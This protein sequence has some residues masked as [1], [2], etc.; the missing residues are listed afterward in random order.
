MLTPWMLA[1]VLFGAFLG[2]AALGLERVQRARGATAGRWGTR[3]GWT[4]ALLGAVLWPLA[5]PLWQRWRA[6][7]LGDNAPSVITTGALRATVIDAT[8][9]TTDGWTAWL[10]ATRATLSEGR[11]ALASGIEA[12]NAALQT[13]DAAGLSLTLVLVWLVLTGLL[14]LRLV[15]GAQSLRALTRRAQD[16]RVDGELVLLTDGF[17]PATV[18]WRAPRIVLPSWVRELDAP[19]RALI[20]AH[21]RAHR[22]ARDPRL[23]WLATLAVVLVPWNPSV[24]WIARRLRLAIELDCDART[25]AAAPQAITPQHYARLLLFMAQHVTPP[26]F[27]SAPLASAMASSRSHLQARIRSMHTHRIDPRSRVARRQR[28]VFGTVTV[29]AVAAACGTRIPSNLTSSTPN[30]VAGLSPDV[31]PVP[32]PN[33]FRD[34]VPLVVPGSASSPHYF[35]FQVERPA[36]MRGALGLRYPTVLRSAGV[37]GQVLASFV[38][39]EDGRVDSLTF[40]ALR[41]DHALFTEAVRA[42]LVNATYEA[43]EV[44]GRRVRQLVQQPFVFAIG[45]S[46]AERAAPGGSAVVVRSPLNDVNTPRTAGREALAPSNE[47]ARPNDVY[48]ESQVEKPAAVRVN[49]GMTYPAALRAAK[50]EGTVLA[51]FVVNEDGLVDVSTFKVLRSSDDAFTASVREAL[52]RLRFLPAEVSG[53]RVKQLV[54]QPF[55]FN[56]AR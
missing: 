26:S 51:S 22:D 29:L 21:E 38:V 32:M 18:G 33:G 45:M 24:W 40:Q 19:L 16:A 50:V 15:R 53:R 36:T 7:P 9:S 43:A 3:G 34:T 14:A 10:L 39:Q 20:M 46:S 17:G 49:A 55:V 42:A 37:E 31:A 13:A 23:V 44:N 54:Q 56:I 28:A 47:A 41:S 5:V 48:L 12:V 2:L 8:A 11:A 27:R 52:P 35:E 4:L 30:D 1:A 25:L 6:T